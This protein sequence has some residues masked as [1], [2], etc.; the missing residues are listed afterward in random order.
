MVET[1]PT[2]VTEP[3]LLRAFG[4]E[5]RRLHSFEKLALSV[6]LVFTLVAF[7]VS[8]QDV[9]RYAGIDFRNRIV[10]ARAMLAGYDPYTLEWHEDM[11]LELL[12]PC[13]DKLV[14]RL[15]APPPTLFLYVLI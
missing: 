1:I 3:W 5:A 2:P 13:H 14:H 8:L 4:L 15:T 7:W 12:D 11:P 10:G 9:S 6:S